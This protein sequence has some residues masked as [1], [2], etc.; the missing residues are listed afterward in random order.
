MYGKWSYKFCGRRE[1]GKA[2]L[3]DKTRSFIF[4]IK[5]NGQSAKPFWKDLRLLNATHSATSQV[6]CLKPSHKNT[7]KPVREMAAVRGMKL[8][9]F[10]GAFLWGWKWGCVDWTCFV[11]HDR[12]CGWNFISNQFDASVLFWRLQVLWELRRQASP[13]SLH[14]AHNFNLILKLG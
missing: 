7:V 14:V 4:V 9:K 8:M 12:D 2:S 5:Y 6:L 1:S 13:A 10:K 11:T 3:K